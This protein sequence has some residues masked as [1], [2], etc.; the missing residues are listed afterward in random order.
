[1]KSN[2]R[3]SRE[4]EWER[5]RDSVQ[6]VHSWKESQITDGRVTLPSFSAIS[7]A[8]DGDIPIREA[9]AAQNV[10]KER[11]L[12]PWRRRCAARVGSSCMGGSVAACFF[13]SIAD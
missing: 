13:P 8:M 3:L 9:V 5:V 2:S 10:R 4:G 1:M 7:A 12:M 6:P 11:R